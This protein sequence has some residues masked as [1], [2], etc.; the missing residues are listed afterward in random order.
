MTESRA[1][2]QAGGQT[3]VVIPAGNMEAWGAQTKGSTARQLVRRL[4]TFEAW[5]WKKT[6]AEGAGGTGTEAEECPAK[7]KGKKEKVLQ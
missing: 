2:A 4:G 6:V 1:H 5:K 7:K 3:I